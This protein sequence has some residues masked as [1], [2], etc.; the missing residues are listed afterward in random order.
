M[1]GLAGWDGAAISSH[2]SAGQA[3]HRLSFLAELGVRDDDPGVAPIADRILSRQSDEGP[4]L[5]RMNIPAAYGGT[6]QDTWAWALCDAPVIV[7]A[8]ARMG[9]GGDSRVTR[10][11][12]YLRG[13]ARENGWSCAVSPALGRFRGPGRASDPCPYATLVMLKALSNFA[14]AR[15]SPEA[16]A[17]AESLLGLWEQ[18]HERHPYMFFMGTDFRKVKAPLVWYD[19]LHVMDVLSG[20]VWL[21]GD[22]RLRDMA[23]VLAAQA[24]AGGRYTAGSVWKAWVDWE[25]GQKKAPSRWVTFLAARALGRMGVLPE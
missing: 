15:D 11:M 19:I 7:G 2:K 13:L 25:F 22:D 17:G 12:A 18:S 24:D 16:H 21:R 14:G 10:A 9:L 20:F 4:F 5:L 1:A 6:G 3:Y 23:S 8:L